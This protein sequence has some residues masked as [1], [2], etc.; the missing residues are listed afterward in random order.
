M[1]STGPLLFLFERTHNYSIDNQVLVPWRLR[2][3]GSA[4]HLPTL[5]WRVETRGCFSISEGRQLT[6]FRNYSKGRVGSAGRRRS[7][8]A[9]WG[10]ETRELQHT[11]CDTISE[12]WGERTHSKTQAQPRLHPSALA[13]TGLLLSTLGSRVGNTSLTFHTPAAAE[14]PTQALDPPTLFFIWRVESRLSTLEM[15]KQPRVSTL[16]PRVGR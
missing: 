8:A 1:I 14:L 12:R 11:S 16:R 15:K 2:R 9:G 6:F 7:V 13:A 3:V 10:L 5:G 4:F